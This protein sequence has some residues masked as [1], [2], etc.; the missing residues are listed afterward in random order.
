MM[1]SLPFT[2]AVSTLASSKL[3]WTPPVQ[4]A[5]HSPLDP[6]EPRIRTGV[7]H[8]NRCAERKAGVGAMRDNKVTFLW[9]SE[10]NCSFWIKSVDS[11]CWWPF[12]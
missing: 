2:F 1:K 7:G 12:S 3:E 6:A 9:M 11:L 8:P 5:L 10:L 4:N